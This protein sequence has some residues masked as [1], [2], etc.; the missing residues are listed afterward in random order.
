MCVNVSFL[1]DNPIPSRFQ[2]VKK[3]PTSISSS[4]PEKGVFFDRFAQ[5][6][7]IYLTNPPFTLQTRAASFQRDTTRVQEKHQST[8]YAQFLKELYLQ[9]VPTAQRR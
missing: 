1:A 3:F 5:H 6:E 2:R 7:E 4:A 8:L 9:S